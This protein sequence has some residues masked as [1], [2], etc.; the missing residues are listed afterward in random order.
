L[1]PTMVH[2]RNL[3][4]LRVPCFDQGFV[5]GVYALSRAGGLARGQPAGI[6]PSPHSSQAFGE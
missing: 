6:L 1:K 5:R 2:L 3:G 4:P